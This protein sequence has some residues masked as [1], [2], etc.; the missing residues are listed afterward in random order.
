MIRIGFWGESDIRLR[1]TK[2]KIGFWGIVYY[3]SS[4]E[5]P[6]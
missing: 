5:P 1:R 6:K 3:N 2:L 4:K